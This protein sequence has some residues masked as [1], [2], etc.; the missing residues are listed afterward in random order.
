MEGS[1]NGFQGQMERGRMLKK[2]FRYTRS[3][4]KIIRAVVC[5]GKAIELNPS[6]AE[7]Y[8]QYA[9]AR[10]ELGGWESIKK[11]RDKFKDFFESSELNKHEY[12]KALLYG[13]LLVKGLE[14]KEDYNAMN[15][16][17]KLILEYGGIYEKV[18]PEDYQDI[19]ED[20]DAAKEKAK[21]MPNLIM[22]R[23]ATPTRM[24]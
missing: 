6:D 19:K 11:A 2:Q 17:L 7:A 16:F 10:M 12:K 14:N 22:T 21:R 23:Q 24:R 1:N 5:F 18:Y 9:D 3:N 15:M 4:E 8:Y 13:H 20:M